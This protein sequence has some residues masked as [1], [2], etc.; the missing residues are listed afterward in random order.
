M[1][2]HAWEVHRLAD[3][4]ERKPGVTHDGAERDGRGVGGED[5]LDGERDAEHFAVL[6]F[7]VG[8]EVVDDAA[9]ALI[10][11][12]GVAIGQGVAVFLDDGAVQIDCTQA[13]F[14]GSHHHANGGAMVRI[15]L[16]VLCLAATG[17]IL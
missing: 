1:N 4:V 15:E 9:D 8:G 7:D 6:L 14:V 5:A 10:V 2:H 13:Q 3:G 12:V 17:G 11:D 16:V